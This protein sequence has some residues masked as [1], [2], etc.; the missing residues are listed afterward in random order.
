[1][2]LLQIY[3]SDSPGGPDKAECPRLKKA[4]LGHENAAHLQN[5]RLDTHYWPKDRL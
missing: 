3:I 2:V 1:M 4:K 5:P